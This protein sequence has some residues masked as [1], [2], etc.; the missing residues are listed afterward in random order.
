MAN[1]IQLRD[2][3]TLLAIVKDGQVLAELTATGADAA[4]CKDRLS[5]LLRDTRSA[6]RGC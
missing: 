2:W 5:E 4:S 3:D 6:C 1:A